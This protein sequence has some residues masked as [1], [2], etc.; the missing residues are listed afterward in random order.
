MPSS[1]RIDA[2]NYG[3]RTSFFKKAHNRRKKRHIKGRLITKDFWISMV[4]LR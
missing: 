3:D 2:L 4:Y 1:D